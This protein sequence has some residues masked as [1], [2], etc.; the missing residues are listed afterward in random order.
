MS[1][2]ERIVQ[3]VDYKKISKN[4]FYKE[5][6]LSNGFLDKNNHPG[7]D[8]LE[9]IIYAYPDINPEWLLTGKGEMLRS[10]EAVT[11]AG[12]GNVTNTG[13][14]ARINTNVKVDKRQY[15][16]DSPDVLRAIIDEKERLLRDKDIYII[17]L[18]ENKD[19]LLREKDERLREKDERLREKDAY[20]LELKELIQELKKK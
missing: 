10:K 17:E 5:T 6:G 2:R 3:F 11:I 18:V 13:N 7:A 16:S 9:R 4:K 15:F 20:I 12:D 1:S 14:N 8:K 19:K